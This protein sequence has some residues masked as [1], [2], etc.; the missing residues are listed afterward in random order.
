MDRW[1]RET[2]ET[3]IV[4]DFSQKIGEPFLSISPF[5]CLNIHPSI[6]PCYRGAAPI[7]RAIINGDLSTGVSVFRLVQEMD[8]GPLLASSALK[9]GDDDNFGEIAEKL[10]VEGSRLLLNGLELFRQGR[11]SFK[12]QDHENAT[13]APR[14]TKAETELSWKYPSK[15][16]HDLVRAMN[17]VPGCFLLVSG[18]RLKIWETRMLPDSGEPGEIIGFHG[19]NP[20]IACLTGALEL[21]QVQP[22]GKKISGGAEWMRGSSFKKGDR[23]I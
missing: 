7:Q 22:E 13:F 9:I 1:R 2:P 15:K 17:P 12:E 5:G 16:V 19:G 23:L 4:V 6:L 18:K 3:I 8:A 14:I 21:V 10:A 11:I 20:V